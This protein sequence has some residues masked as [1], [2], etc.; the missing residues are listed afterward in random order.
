MEC[1]PCCGPRGGATGCC[2]RAALRGWWP[3][4]ART[5]RGFRPL[6]CR[7]QAV[8][9]CL[10]SGHELAIM[11]YALPGIGDTF[12]E[13]D[14]AGHTVFPGRRHLA[15]SDAPRRRGICGHED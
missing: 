9:W 11:R 6:G 14:E 15:V 7:A 8:G 12:I 2:T 1:A 13:I 3:D 5:R 10:L 4:A